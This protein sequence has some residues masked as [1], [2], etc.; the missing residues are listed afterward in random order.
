MAAPEAYLP[1]LRMSI[2]MQ[3]DPANKEPA[4]AM[5]PERKEWLK[6]AMSNL[7]KNP[8]DDMKLALK[9]V[10]SGETEDERVQ[11]L[12]AIASFVEQVDL[13]RDLHKIGGLSVVIAKLDDPSS[14]VRASAAHVIGTTVHNNPEPQKWASE[15]GALEALSK[16]LS[17]KDASPQ[18]LAKALFGISSLIRQNDQATI[19]Y[20][21][22][23]K[24]VALIL[25]V[26]KRDVEHQDDLLPARRKA[27]SV[28][29]YLVTRAPAIVPSTAPFC[30]PVLA[31]A[32][33]VYAAD[34]DF[35]E[36]AL[37]V[38]RVFST[39]DRVKVTDVD[40]RQVV[41][42]ASHTMDLAIQDEHELATEVCQE[43]LAIWKKVE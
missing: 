15:L 26:L 14:K 24:G 39:N 21:K 3:Q 12:D 13:A 32:L 8:V 10:E 42:S 36:N 38:L 29:L 25:D 30:V 43:L 37:L 35:R 23:L 11:G 33:K 40:K 41:D 31:S 27:V 4:K 17:R 1:L 7:L 2:G 34:H 6:E 28:L 9:Q 22:D 19:K 20:V 16:I 18:E 5:D